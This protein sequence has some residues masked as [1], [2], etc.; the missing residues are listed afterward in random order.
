MRVSEL[1]DRPVIDPT[2]ARKLGRVVDVLLDPTARQLVGVIIAPEGGDS[3]EHKISASLIAR[4]GVDAVMLRDATDQ[5]T[6]EVDAD[7]NGYLD[8]TSLVGLEVLDDGGNHVGH[9]NDARIDPDSLAITAYDLAETGWRHWL[10]RQSEIGPSEVTAWSRE[11]ML[12]N[13]RVAQ[14]Q[15]EQPPDEPQDPEPRG[16]APAADESGGI[17]PS[18]SPTRR[19]RAANRNVQADQHS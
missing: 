1:K 19:R 14:Q 16:E 5:G 6:L 18:A 13:P 3:A 8:Y 15:S 11:L 17:T 12:I 7:R 4:I 2:T 10:G 9:L